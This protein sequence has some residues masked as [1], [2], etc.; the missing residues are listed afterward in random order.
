MSRGS[1]PKG[2]HVAAHR[3]MQGGHVGIRKQPFEVEGDCNSPYYLM[4]GALKEIGSAITAGILT[5]WIRD[6]ETSFG[7][8]MALTRVGRHWAIAA[9]TV[10]AL[11]RLLPDRETLERLVEEYENNHPPPVR[12][13]AKPRKASS[14]A[15]NLNV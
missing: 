5:R 6:G 3:E 4:T 12:R 8:P 2:F 9:A 1:L 14:V 15:I 13:H 7:F 11:K 10:L